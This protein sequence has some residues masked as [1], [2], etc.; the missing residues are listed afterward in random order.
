MPN[1]LSFR[2]P[3]EPEPSGEGTVKVIVG[4]FASSD[5]RDWPGPKGLGRNPPS[6]ATGLRIERG[7]SWG[8]AATPALIAFTTVAFVRRQPV[9]FRRH[10]DQAKYQKLRHSRQKRAMHME[11][12]TLA[13]G[14]R[15]PDAADW[16]AIEPLERGRY[17]V[18]GCVAGEHE[19]AFAN[20]M[21]KSL[22]DARLA[23]IL[24]ARHR[25]ATKVYVETAG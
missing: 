18:A 1:P 17:N 6:P 4:K 15:A 13:A 5:R 10:R 23:G 9:K 24:W 3:A 2:R 14:T 12:V 25:G 22:D 19:L 20:E 11:I 7:G 16:I 8:P 21:F